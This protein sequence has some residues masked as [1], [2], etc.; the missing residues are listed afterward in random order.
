MTAPSPSAVLGN[1]N[2]TSTPNQS[3]LPPPDPM[4]GLFPA[5]FLSVGSIGDDF[6]PTTMF[7]NSSDL[8]FGQDE[9]A[10]ERDFG[11]WFNQDAVG[12]LDMTSK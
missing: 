5:E 11:Q 3:S 4:N 1:T 9:A 6:D 10:F 12:S 2:P 8:P 7:R